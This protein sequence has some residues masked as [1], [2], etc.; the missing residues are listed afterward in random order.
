MQLGIG[1]YAYAWSI[2]VPGHPPAVP[3]TAYNLLEEA[4]RLGVGLLQV[5]DNVE[6]ARL[7]PADLD[8]FVARARASKIGIELG[9]L[10]LEM[11]NLR[12]HLDLARRLGCS[13]LRLV[14]D[15]PGDEP[16]PDEVVA[17]LRMVLPEFEAAGVRLAI[18]NHDRFPSAT[19]AWMVRELGPRQAGICL[20]T[21]NSFGALEGPDTVVQ[22]LAEH[23]LC[24]HVKDF[25]IRRM[26]HRMGF[27]VEGCPAGRGRL[28]VPWLLDRLA[29]SPHPFNMI[30]ENW[31]PPA[32][33]LPETLLRERAWAEESVRYLRQF[34]PAG[35]GV[36]GM[37]DPA[38]FNRPG[39][40]AVPTA[41][42]RVRRP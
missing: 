9:T 19:L 1:S 15:S 23:T 4:E 34:S 31:V 29:S 25:T 28:D 11:G 42:E 24:L 39:D 12:V 32:D 27:V 17:R 41:E 21:V 5:C 13:F 16:S 3:M 36:P 7:S 37:S 20:D 8:R 10:G 35:G 38:P 40:S 30:L 6:L 26:S 22:N 18:E 14:V 33:T 2:G